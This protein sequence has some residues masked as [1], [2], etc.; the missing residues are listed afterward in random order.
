MLRCDDITL[1]TCYDVTFKLCYDVTLI[2]LRLNST[3]VATLRCYD[4]KL[5]TVL[6]VFCTTVHIRYCD[7]CFFPDKTLRLSKLP[8]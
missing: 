6:T 8:F 4:V 1:K 3:F 5:E 7:L 2:L